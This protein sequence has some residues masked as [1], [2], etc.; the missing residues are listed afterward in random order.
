[1]KVNLAITYDKE[2]YLC[3]YDEEM[4]VISEMFVECIKIINDFVKCL[5][6]ENIVGFVSLKNI[7]GLRYEGDKITL[8]KLKEI[9]NET[10]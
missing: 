3:V 8:E 9:T 5:I 10:N 7:S 4:N 2:Y 1:M 6:G